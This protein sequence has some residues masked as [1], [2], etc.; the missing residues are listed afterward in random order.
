M[1]GKCSFWAKRFDQ[2]PGIICIRT[3]KIGL[4]GYGTEK[5]DDV[6][7]SGVTVYDVTV[8]GKFKLN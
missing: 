3:D 4:V 5:V 7:V 1:P 8:Y 2:Y 6:T